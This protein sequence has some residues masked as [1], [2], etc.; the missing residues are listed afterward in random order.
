MFAKAWGAI[1]SV[2]PAPD[3]YITIM[4]YRSAA[5]LGRLSAATLFAYAFGPVS[6][7]MLAVSLIL[8]WHYMGANPTWLGP[9]VTKLGP[10]LREW[11]KAGSSSKQR[12]RK[13]VVLGGIAVVVLLSPLLLCLYVLLHPVVLMK[14]AKAPRQLVAWLSVALITTV[15]FPGVA[16]LTLPA[17]ARRL[18]SH[19]Y[20]TDELYNADLGLDLRWTC[21]NMSFGVLRAVENAVLLLSVLAFDDSGDFSIGSGRLW[22]P[23]AIS[24]LLCVVGALLFPVY[25]WR[26]EKIRAKVRC[27]PVV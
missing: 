22:R 4:A 14:A 1:K 21:S 10:A 7:V 15:D 20:D 2:R 19:T 26:V 27:V 23:F 3:P 25:L 12:N 13:C 24:A 9:L 11:V 17:W 5:I 6:F 16:H 8:A 18:S